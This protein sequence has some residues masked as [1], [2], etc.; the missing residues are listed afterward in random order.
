MQIQVQNVTRNSITSSLVA[1]KP[2]LAFDKNFTSE[3][4]HANTFKMIKGH[5]L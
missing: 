5:L 1:I 2:A 3:I 4:I